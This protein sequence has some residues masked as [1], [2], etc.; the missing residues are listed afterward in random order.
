VIVDSHTH[1]LPDQFRDQRERWLSNDR[2]FASLF[3]DTAARTV[4]AEDLIGEMDGAGVDVS[5]SL[6]YGWT[7]RDSAR[8]SND[9]LLAAALQHPGRIVPFCSVDPG[10]GDHAVT[11]VQRCLSLGA[12]GIGEL[13]A[14][15]QDWNPEGVDGLRPIMSLA[16]EAAIPVVVHASEP[17]GHTYPGKGTSSP[18]RLL[19]MAAAFPDVAFV[20]AH[21]GGGLPFYALMPE[22][23]ETLSNVYFDS[24]AAPFLY[25]PDVYKV[26]ATTAGPGRILFGSDYPLLKQGRA[27][28]G[29]REAC[30]GDKDITRIL[31]GNAADLFGIKRV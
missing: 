26:A 11:E 2:T 7:D 9:Y 10:W 19:G 16:V 20:F 25:R 15:T 4:S 28:R 24:A 18:D 29:V 21:F 5:V 3:N 23:A 17:V 31:G 1:I 30:L 14:D 27:L 12:R 13:H 6:G 22:V 8:V